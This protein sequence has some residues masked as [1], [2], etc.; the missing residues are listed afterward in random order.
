MI[1]ILIF[2]LFI[3]SYYRQLS[4]DIKMKNYRIKTSPRPLGAITGIDS[5]IFILIIVE[6]SL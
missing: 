2:A 4:A 1:F 5:I 6:N 3:A